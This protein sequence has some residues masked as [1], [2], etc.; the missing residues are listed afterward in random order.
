[1][2]K[3]MHCSNTHWLHVY[4]LSRHCHHLIDLYH[5]LVTHPPLDM[6]QSQNLSQFMTRPKQIQYRKYQ[7]NDLNAHTYISI[8]RFWYN[9]SSSRYGCSTCERT[10]PT[11]NLKPR[12]CVSVRMTASPHCCC[13]HNQVEPRGW[14]TD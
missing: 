6:S 2:S 11:L 4:I 10:I 3:N 13:G 5:T 8:Y 14:T 1:M 9:Q 7:N 12:R